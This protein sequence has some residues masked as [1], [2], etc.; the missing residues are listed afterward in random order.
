M[1]HFFVAFH[2]AIVVELS[3][4]SV[5]LLYIK[6]PCGIFALWDSPFCRGDAF[7]QGKH[8]EIAGVFYPDQY[9][10]AGFLKATTLQPG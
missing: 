6:S 1:G 7:F 2:H 10:P 3:L 8:V 9:P 5:E 4:D